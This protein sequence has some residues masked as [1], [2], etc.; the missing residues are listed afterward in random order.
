MPKPEKPLR[1]VACRRQID[2]GRDALSVEKGV[3]G[4]RGFVPLGE[5]VLLCSDECASEHFTDDSESKRLSKVHQ[6]RR[7]IP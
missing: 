5:L 2:L 4:P 6:L 3:I 7:R 1:C